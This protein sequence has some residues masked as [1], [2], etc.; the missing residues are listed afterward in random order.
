[1]NYPLFIAR[2]LSLKSGGR[3]S[4]P[5]VS[6]AIA[7]VALSVFVMIAAI[8]IV[9]GFKDEIRNKLVGFNSH[10]SVYATATSGDTDNILT[11]DARLTDLLESTPYI[12]RYSVQAAIPAVLKT[13]DD[14]KGVYLRG[15]SGEDCEQ[16]IFSN[17]K[18]GNPVD[19]DSAENKNKIIL[20]TKASTELGLHAGDKIDTYF[21]S[22]E[23]RVRR[24]E[25]AGIYDTHF[26]QY[27]DITAFGSMALVRQLG[28]LEEGTGTYLQVMTDDF[29]KIDE[30]AY[31]LQMRLNAA[32]SE[33]TLDHIYRVDNVK[34]QGM[35]YFGWL[36]LLDMN[37]VVI[38][39]LMMIVGCVT[40]VSGMLMIILEKK[41]LVGIL[42]A[43]GTPTKQVRRI[44]IWL[45]IRIAVIGLTIGNVLAIAVLY[46]QQKSHFI[47]L[48]PDSYYIDFVPVHL[49]IPYIVALNVGVIA[50]IYAVLILPSRFIAGISPAE[51]MRY[52]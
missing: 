28:G 14:F 16:F 5:S 23:L 48:D 40:L 22:D 18:E 38:L 45:A 9:F 43:L 17:L 29:D 4:A 30:N 12:K 46:A 8:A 21:I 37:V 52:E 15:M 42:K 49:S 33:G 7:A 34:N 6:V 20:S 27:D 10:I 41:R 19:F 13:P 31:D 50:V 47:P 32:S 36:E 3:R 1:M 51:T 24:M 44:F 2:R 26:S 11:L 39:V 25:V 35:G